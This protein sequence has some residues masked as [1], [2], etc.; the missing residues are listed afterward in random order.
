M[1]WLILFVAFALIAWAL[2]C[3][4]KKQKAVWLA[5]KADSYSFYKSHTP[6]GDPDVFAGFAIFAGI[7]AAI[8][9]IVVIGITAAGYSSV[10]GSQARADRLK[11]TIIT[12][13]ERSDA[14][15][16]KI[17]T[18]LVEQYPEYEAST[19]TAMVGQTPG[20]LAVKFPELQASKTFIDYTTQISKLQDRIYNTKIER[21]RALEGIQSKQNDSMNILTFMLP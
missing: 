2:Y 18:F 6:G 3:K 4:W 15:E 12:N 8:L 1:L 13:Q 20:L 5:S 21:Q 7:I 11:D 14:I 16:S 9:L 10:I 19:L 17:K